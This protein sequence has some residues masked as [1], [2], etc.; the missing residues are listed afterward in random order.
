MNEQSKRKRGRP[1][2]TF[3][4]KYPRRPGGRSTRMFAKWVGLVGRCTNPK[5]HNYK[6]YG[7]RG[8]TVDP[9]WLGQSGF[10]N[11]HNDMGE[12][13]AG[14]TLERKDNNL[15]YS[16]ANCRWATW[17]EQANNRRPG[18]PRPNPDCLSQKAKAA[19]LP[20]A[21]A[22]QRIAIL[23]WDEQRALSTP[24]LKRGGQPGHGR[25]RSK[26]VD[27]AAAAVLQSIA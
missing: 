6:D 5:F 25:P 7:A 1:V 3:A 26:A 18:G 10:D 23:G 4:G 19:G 24:K 12:C 21:V 9:R 14:L 22:Y 15:G 16:K 13:P 17:A 27:I 11:F 8:I 2:G 20:Y